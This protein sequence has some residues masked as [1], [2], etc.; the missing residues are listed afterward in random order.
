MLSAQDVVQRVAL[1]PFCVPREEFSEADILCAAREERFVRL[2]QR[3]SRRG[4]SMGVIDVRFG[5][6]GERLHGDVRRAEKPGAK[7]SR[8]E[9]AT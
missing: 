1:Q 7:L 8:E 2:V 9:T 5:A 4:E 6:V 3:S